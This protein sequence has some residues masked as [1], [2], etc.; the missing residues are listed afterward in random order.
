MDLSSFSSLSPPKFLDHHFNFM[1]KTQRYFEAPH[2]INWD[3][4]YYRFNEHLTTSLR[5]KFPFPTLQFFHTF[6]LIKL[7]PSFFFLPTNDGNPRYC[8]KC[9]ISCIPKAVMISCLVAS[10]VDLIK[11]MAVLFLF[12]FWCDSSSYF[13]RIA[14]IF[15][16]SSPLALQKRRLSFANN[17]WVS[18]GPLR[19]RG[20]PL[21][22]PEIVACWIRPWRPSV[23]SRKRKGDS[24]SP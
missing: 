20:K 2:S 23:Q 4:L 17:K 18:A 10:V 14:R 9:T 5:Q 12:T 13:S 24:W 22:S 19:Q 21:I 3:D 7:K 8:S 15:L 6:S 1:A 16:H 11:K